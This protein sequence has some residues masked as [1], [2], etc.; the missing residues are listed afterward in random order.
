MS[1]K[2]KERASC[3]L[4]SIITPA[5][6]RADYL[7]ET[8]ESVLNQE[9]PRIE[10]IVLD[11]GSTDNTREVLSSYVGRI[12]WESHPNMG[13]TRTVNKGIEMARGEIIAV[14]NSD[15]P[16][17][18]GAVGKAVAFLQEHPDAL[19]AYPDWDYIDAAS[20]TT[21]HIQV[22]DYDYLY[23]VRRHHCSVGPG[24]FIRRRAFQLA[25]PRDPEFLYVGD[26]EFWLRLG[27]FGPFAR[28]PQ[29]LATFRVHSTS[30]SLAAQGRGMARE[31]IRLATKYY[32][33]PGLPNE[34][35]AIRREAFAW[36]YYIAGIT[37]G[38]D[39]HTARRC[40]ARA[41][42]YHPRSILPQ[43]KQLLYGAAPAPL[44]RWAGRAFRA[45]RAGTNLAR[46]CARLLLG[47]LGRR[48]SASIS[49]D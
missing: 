26:F 6:N 23:M 24:A 48:G 32:S 27:L 35:L 7:A 13:E 47:R 4:V 11:D 9:Y 31:H 8:I 37:A 19:V 15:D 36:A 30:A 14:V 29:T 2:E 12:V 42:L 21:G 17:L 16:L 10:Y 41:V 1:A 3:P 25:G 5:Y 44:A 45:F 39:R 28:I 22:P 34:V 46:R 20:K 33:T 43:W 49:R 40:Y 18:P 38:R